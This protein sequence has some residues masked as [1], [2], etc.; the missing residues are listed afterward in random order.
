LDS[1]QFK[2]IAKRLDVIISLLLQS[3]EVDGRKLSLRS[4]IKHLSE[5]GLRPIEIA[6][7]LGKNPGYI[8]KELVAIR[9][10][11]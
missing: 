7:V 9:R 8:N 2:T 3:V 11:S 6:G 10:E 5:M 4:Q 1:D